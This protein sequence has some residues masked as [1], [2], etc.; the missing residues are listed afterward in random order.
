MTMRTMKKKMKTKPMLSA[1]DKFVS[2]IDAKYAEARQ[3]LKDDDLEA[4]QATLAQIAKAHAKTSLSLRN[5]LIKDG[6]IKG[7]R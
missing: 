2:Q 5:V 4:A 1:F 6:R 7:E 3:Q